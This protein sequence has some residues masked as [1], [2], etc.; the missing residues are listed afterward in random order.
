MLK[1]LLL[2]LFA[3]MNTV[4]LGFRPW[5]VVKVACSISDDLVWPVKTGVKSVGRRDA[6]REIWPR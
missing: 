4:G 2:L 1:A 5:D 6:L 3:F